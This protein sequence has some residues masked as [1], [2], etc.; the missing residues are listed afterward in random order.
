[1]NKQLSTL[2][3]GIIF[4]SAAVGVWKLHQGEAIQPGDPAITS[5][6]LLDHLHYLA[7]NELK[8]RE[9]GTPEGSQ[10]ARY[11]ARQMEA[12]GIQ[13]AGTEGYFQK[14]NY[15]SSL[16]LGQ[17]NTF[18]IRGS[19][20][21]FRVGED[22]TPLGFSSKGSLTANVVFVGYGFSID[23]SITW[24]DYEDVDVNRKWALIIRGGPEG[25]NPHSPFE[26][27][28]AL[29]KKVLVARDHGAQGVLLVSPVVDK[30]KDELI[31]LRFDQSQ[32]GA[33]LPVL[34]I[35]QEIANQILQSVGLD[36][37]TVQAR[38]DSTRQPQSIET[39]TW[40]S[41]TVSIR[42]NKVRIAN[43]IGVIPGTDP[44]LKKEY[45]VIGAHFDHLG[46]GGPGSGSLAQDTMAVHNGADDNA[47]GITGVLEIGEQL[48]ARREELKRSV[49]LMGF[50]AE[51]KGLLGSKYF[52]EHPT[53]PLKNIAAMINM[54][55]IGRMKDSS[56]TI[57]G[58]GTSPGLKTILNE[59]NRNYNLKLN[60][61]EEGYGPSDHASFYTQDV[62][63]VFFFTGVHEDYHKPTDDVDKINLEGEITVANLATDLALYLSQ[64]AERPTFTEAGPKEAQSERRRFKVTFGII[65]AYASSATGLEIDGVKTGGPADKAGLKKGDIIIA[66]GG[67]DVKDIYDY[68]YRLSE[69]KPG[70]VVS[71]T[72]QRGTETLEFSVQL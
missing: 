54:D 15:I 65:P 69:L 28:L 9:A 29:R 1:M 17:R 49:L 19:R 21:S 26:P 67:K 52:V 61:S 35:R 27:H 33:G 4:I 38:L 24:N 22:F 39:P 14:F 50:N 30:E 36:L 10:A 64:V 18:R 63:V 43:V 41:A 55:M 34:Q 71:V 31:P 56:L 47:S 32:R 12:S 23:D 60:F 57:G 11:V 59:L 40:V 66:I 51:E 13:P 45:V 6:E 42:K 5:Q 7:S 37:K 20:K 70:E 25:D 58:V 48:A 8:G 62:P 72:I 44:M 53:V 2:L 68:M 3:V 16:T 46:M